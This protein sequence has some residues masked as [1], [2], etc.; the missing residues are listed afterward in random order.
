[1]LFSVCMIASCNGNSG[2][3]DT[4][5]NGDVTTTLDEETTTAEP[6]DGKVVYTVTVVDN[7]GDPIEGVRVQLCV[8]G[9]CMPMPKATD[10][11]GVATS[12]RMDPQDYEVSVTKADGYQFDTNTKYHFEAGSTS[13]EIT[14]IAEEGSLANPLF[15]SEN[16][17]T[18]TVEDEKI[19]YIAFRNGAGKKFI[20]NDANAV[21]HYNDQTYTPD[22]SGK[23]LIELV[24][25]AGDT[26]KPI[27][28]GF[29]AKNETTSTFAYVIESDPG[30]AD[31]PYTLTDLN[32]SEAKRS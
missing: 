2:N 6:N 8:G 16:T 3:T 24:A 20:V 23:I 21:L 15:I 14:L 7:N 13:M 25:T 5:N 26:K 22:N 1:M 10:A 17:G 30:T 29:S 18:V 11:N 31:N 28:I 4:E 9:T 27:V 19:Y 12:R 32:K